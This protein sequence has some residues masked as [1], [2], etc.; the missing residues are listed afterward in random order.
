MCNVIH[1]LFGGQASW[2]TCVLGAG[3]LLV[4]YLF[5]WQLRPRL[6]AKYKLLG[7]LGPLTVMLVMIPLMAATDGWGGEVKMVGSVCKLSDPDALFHP[8]CLPRPKWPAGLVWR[9]VRS[10]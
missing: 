6:P 9:A 8:E 2:Q 4:L 1:K 3:C 10:T 5:K 7:N